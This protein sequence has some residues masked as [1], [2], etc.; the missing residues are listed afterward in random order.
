MAPLKPILLLQR[1]QGQFPTLTLGNSQM[2]PV[3]PAAEGS[4]DTCAH[5][6]IP[7]HTHMHNFKI[8]QVNL[9]EKE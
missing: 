4:K 5:V 9:Y 2:L 7:T 1:T 6:H 8:L 3:T